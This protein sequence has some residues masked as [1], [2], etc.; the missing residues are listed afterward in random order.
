MHFGKILI[1]FGLILVVLGL[2]LTLAGKIPL[3]GKLPGDF[4]FERDHFSFYLPLTSCL[5][6]SLLIS[7]LLWFLRR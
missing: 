2:G 4:R 7:L 5:L 1:I 6:I 3:L